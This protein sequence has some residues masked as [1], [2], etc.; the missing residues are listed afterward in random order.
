MEGIIGLKNRGNTCY[1][2]TSIQCLSH[3]TL[4]TEYFLSNK[5]IND[6]NNRCNETNGIKTNDIIISKEYAKLIKAIWTSNCSIEPRSFHELIQKSDNKFEGYEQ[7]DSQELLVLILDNL[8]EGLKY[9][10]EITYSGKVENTL[11]KLV[12]ESIKRWKVD[13]NNKYSIIAELFFGQF[14][15]KVISLESKNKDKIEIVSKKFEMFN[16]L[17]IPVEGSTLYESLSK[18]F[19]KETLESPFYNEKTKKYINCCREI[20]LMR[21]PKYLIIILKRY[22]NLMNGSQIKSNNMISFP[23]DDLDLTS[24]SEGYDKIKCKL[25]LV[26]IGCHRGILSGGHYYSICKNYNNNKWYKYDDDDVSEFMLETNK[27]IIFKDGY[28]LIYEKIE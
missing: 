24:Y 6:L 9:D 8:H 19:E 14:I 20:K 16:M 4:L 18:H 10:V 21:I 23:I 25:K 13:L 26:S 2:N 12:I 27:N 28:I 7:Q 1:L 22:K 5:Y 15:N 3:L 11:D 17:I